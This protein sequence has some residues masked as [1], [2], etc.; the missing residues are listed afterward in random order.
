MNPTQKPDPTPGALADLT[1]ADILRCAARYLELRGWTQG[2]PYEL[3]EQAAFPPACPLGA[4]TAA[5]YG[6]PAAIDGHSDGI[7]ATL[8]DIT[9]GYLADFLRQDGYVPEPDVIRCADTQI[10]ADWNDDPWRTVAQVIDILGATADEWD[11]THATEDDLETYA[12]ACVWAEKNPTRDG[13][14]AWRA[15]Q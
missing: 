7:A 6:Y 12:D 2:V 14:L 1:P 5:I 3:A 8:R 13:F 10:V 15:A 4:I 11:W 9:I